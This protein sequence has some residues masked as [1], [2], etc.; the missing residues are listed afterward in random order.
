MKQ[1]EKIK[2]DIA[3]CTSA[4]ELCGYLEGIRIAA[5]LYCK[6]NFP[7]EIILEEKHN[8]VSL[9]GMERFLECDRK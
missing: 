2:Q 3:E 7:D 9:Y 4:G 5:F 1:Y 6:Q 8:S